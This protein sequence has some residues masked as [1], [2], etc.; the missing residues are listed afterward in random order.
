MRLESWALVALFLA[1][2][3]CGSDD[4]PGAKASGGS[5]GSGAS[6][7][8]G[9]SSGGSTSG[10]SGGAAGSAGVGGSGA[11]G[12][13]AGA[14]GG[15]GGK[16]GVVPGAT[17]TT[18]PP[19][20]VGLGEAALG[21]F[22][23]SIGGRGVVVRNGYLAYSWGNASQKGDI[24][25]AAKPIYGF[26]LFDAVEK[27]LIGSIDEKVA[28]LIPGLAA[29]NPSL[30]NKDA[31]I[32]F[33]HFSTQTSCYGVTEEP[34]KAFDYNDWQ[35]AL[36]WD[37]LFLKVW[38]A[39]YDDV[40]AK[41]LGPELCAVIQCEDQPT[42]LAFGK[43]DRPGRVAISPRDFAR[44][45]LLYL[46]G[47]SWDGTT[48]LPSAVVTQIVTSPLPNSIPQTQGNEAELLA[49]QRSIGSTTKPDNQTDHLGSYS[50]MWWINGVDR[51]GKTLLPDA[52]TDTYMAS[53]HG[54]KRAVVVIP[55][56]D[57]VVSWNDTSISD[58]AQANQALK[59]LMAAVQ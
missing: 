2:S 18:K 4:G 8:G 31:N 19:A 1:T 32:T 56:L 16:P 29:L 44:F 30:G 21:A 47:G 13:T 38:G 15:G 11:T 40:D 55:S 10:G 51:N 45:G 48:L 22:S 12:G 53:G 24:A 9:T 20:D 27:K 14:S 39:T 54:S 36:F 6:A 33:R 42:F 49:G 5:G 37:T 7:T 28:P 57:L 59:L 34:G 3:G 43:N 17:W 35:M 50:F 46:R 23:S 25:S 52:P 58:F 26:F 41:V